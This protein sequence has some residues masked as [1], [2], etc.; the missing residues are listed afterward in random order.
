LFSLGSGAANTDLVLTW[1]VFRQAGF[2]IAF[3]GRVYPLVL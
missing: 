2:F 1:G 3:L